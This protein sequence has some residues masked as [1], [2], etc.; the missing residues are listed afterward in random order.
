MGTVPRVKIRSHTA[1]RFT[2]GRLRLARSS[3]VQGSRARRFARR[4]RLGSASPSF[5]PTSGPGRSIRARRRQDRAGQRE[6]TR[7]PTSS[8]A[9]RL[10]GSPLSFPLMRRGEALQ[11]H[12]QLGALRDT[13]AQPLAH[14]DGYEAGVHLVLAARPSPAPAPAAGPARAAAPRRRRPIRGLA[15]AER[16]ARE[17]Q[18]PRA[19]KAEHLLPDQVDAVAR[20]GAERRVRVVGEDGSCRRR[21]RCRPASPTRCGCS[22]A[23]SPRR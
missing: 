20:H 18:V 9:G 14:R 10:R 4:R 12:A 19:V 3:P 5:T 23:R 13:A 7:G 8:E 11:R 22:P 21:S 1:G 15:G 6:F 2:G 16:P 17:R